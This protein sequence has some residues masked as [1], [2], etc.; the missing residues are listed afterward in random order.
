MSEV[1][2]AAALAA[3]DEARAALYGLVARLFYA[4]P[5]QEVLG[6][7]V[8][9]E[10]CGE[11]GSELGRAWRALADASRSAFPVLLENEHTELFVGTGRAEV[12]PYLTHYTIKYATENPLVDLRQ[13]L[14]RW[15]IARR[16]G[17]SEP[18]DHIAGVCEAM[19]FAI[20]VQQRPEREQKSFFDTFV[21]PGGVAFCDATVASA[22][23]NFYRPVARLA[24]AFFE[25][26][27]EAF[28]ML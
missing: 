9:A 14:Q 13:Q 20:A 10:A 12:T 25:I 1:R 2:R 24:R 11:P 21:Y 27:R 19:R 7:I 8:H 3:E 17:A 4:A 16:D 23:A 5:S 22:R 6:S 26:E 15:G 28:L 18:E